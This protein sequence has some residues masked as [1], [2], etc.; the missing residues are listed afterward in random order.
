[1]NVKLEL[2]QGINEITTGCWVWLVVRWP[3]EGLND[4]PV[5]PIAVGANQLRFPG[6]LSPTFT[7]QV[8]VPSLF[9]EHLLEV[10]SIFCGATV[11]C[12][13]GGV[14]I[15][16]EQ[17]HNAVRGCAPPDPV[18]VNLALLQGIVEI[19]TCTDFPGDN[20]PPGGLK[21]TLL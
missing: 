17:F 12:G 21:D 5:P 8:Y 6:E 4:I 3:F 10:G 14:T 7:L 13:V 9:C 2:L 20:V 19:V 1:M 16:G 11:I 18:K 15:V